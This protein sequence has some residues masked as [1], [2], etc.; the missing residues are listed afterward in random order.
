MFAWY[1]IDTKKPHFDKFI[2]NSFLMWLEPNMWR[3]FCD[4]NVQL[5][6]DNTLNSC[7][8]VKLVHI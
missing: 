8:V 5:K 6:V 2:Y 3:I 1:G 4:V 7:Y